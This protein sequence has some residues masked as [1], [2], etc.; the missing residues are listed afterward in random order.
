[1]VV[2]SPFLCRLRRVRD[3]LYRSK[4]LLHDHHL[5]F[6][7]RKAR[8]WYVSELRHAERLYYYQFSRRLSNSKL[9]A[10]PPQW[11]ST[12][13]T[14]C[15]LRKNE[16]MLLLIHDGKLHLKNDDN[17]ECLNAVFDSQC[18]AVNPQPPSKVAS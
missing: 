16:A 7:Y 11:W 6:T 17:D 18:P 1:M 4:L 14:A 9:K 5:S 8:N 2:C 13:K 10:N 15:S 3:R 12:A